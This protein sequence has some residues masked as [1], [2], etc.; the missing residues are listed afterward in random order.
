MINTLFHP[1]ERAAQAFAGVATP[2]PA[3]RDYMP[4]QHRA[5]FGML[6]FLPIGTIDAKGAPVASILT[7]RPGFVSSPDPNTLR[8]GA[9]A[10]PADPVAGLLV[11][12]APVGVLGIDLATR[13]R[14]R[15]NGILQ[16]VS[17]EA[18]TIDVTQSFGNCPQYIQTRFWHDADAAPGPVEVVRGL[19]DAARAIVD[20]ADTFFIA[21][22]SGTGAGAMGGVDISHRGGRP[23]FVGIEG[24]GLIVPDFH[25][26]GFFN[27]LGNLLLDPRAALLFVDWSTGS[28]LHLTGTVEVLWGETRGFAGAERLWRVSVEAGWRRQRAL[29]MQWS[30]GQYAPQLARTGTWAGLS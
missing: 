14:N 4:E 12:G 3:I 5:F 19:D 20:T 10:D 16:T 7:G 25:G 1:G 27:T 24:D 21:S 9:H 17:P 15:A 22:A 26:N 8:L 30:F 11:P 6:G 23:G 18:M 2:H 29:P 28:L 13:R